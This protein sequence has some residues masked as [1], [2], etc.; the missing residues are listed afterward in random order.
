[1]PTITWN[2]FIEKTT[3]LTYVKVR[4]KYLKKE[5]LFW[6][7]VEVCKKWSLTT[8]KQHNCEGKF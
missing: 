5:D 2:N 7:W 4:E 8:L 6:F 3:I 1:M